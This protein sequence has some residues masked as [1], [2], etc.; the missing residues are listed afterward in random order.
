MKH[1]FKIVLKLSKTKTAINEEFQWQ[2]NYQNK[3]NKLYQ[4]MKGEILR[5]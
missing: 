4:T 2:N 3:R 5:I 1:W